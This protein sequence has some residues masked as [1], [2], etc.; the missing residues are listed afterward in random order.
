MPIV[1]NPRGHYANPKVECEN[2]GNHYGME[3]ARYRQAIMQHSAACL[4]ILAH[5]TKLT[6][7]SSQAHLPGTMAWTW[8]IP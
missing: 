3:H 6:T 5:P 1:Q 7:I 2:Y 8:K 4:E